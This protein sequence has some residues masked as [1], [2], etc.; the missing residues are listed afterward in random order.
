MIIS[1]Q[2]RKKVTIHKSKKAILSI[3]QKEIHENL[4]E[5]DI[6]I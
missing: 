1:N 3:N 2:G 5:A 4:L 6:F